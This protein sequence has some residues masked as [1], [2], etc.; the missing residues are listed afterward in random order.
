M[1]ASSGSVDE[2][3]RPFLAKGRRIA[4]LLASKGKAVKAQDT[5]AN[6][7]TADAE[8]DGVLTEFKTLTPPHA[9]TV[10]LQI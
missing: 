7:R 10:V 5:L 8:V 6:Q 4:E 3:A 1:G 2:S 9:T